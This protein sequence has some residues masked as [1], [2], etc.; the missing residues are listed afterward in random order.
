MFYERSLFAWN[1]LE[2]YVNVHFA[3]AKPEN[4]CSP[5]IIVFFTLRHEKSVKERLVGSYNQTE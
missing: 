4:R 3:E 2:P 5:I 1:K